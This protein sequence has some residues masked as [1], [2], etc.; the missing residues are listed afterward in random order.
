MKYLLALDQGTSSSRSI[1]F[2]QHG[3]L[4]AI[5]QQEL[6]Q[7]YPQNSWV[8][9][10]PMDIWQQQC[11]TAHSVLQQLALTPKDIAAIAITNQR[12]TTVVW[13][14]QSGLPIYPAIVWQD[15]RTFAYCEQLKHAGHAATILAK[16]G[17]VLDAYF[18][19]SKL[20][21]ILQHVPNARARAE[22]GQLAFGT[23]D[24]WL[25]WKLS[26]G[27]A[28][29]T[30]VSNASRTMLW[31]IHSQSW[32]ADL[33]KLFDIP[34][35]LLPEVFPSSH[36]FADC[37]LFGGSIP[38]AG[39][40]GDQQ[41]A[42]F[43]Q[44]CFNAGMA[45]NTYGTGCFALLHSGT[46]VPHS[47][48]GLISTHAAQIDQ[49]ANYALEGSV[50]IGG[51]LVQWLRDGLNAVQNAA[52]IE[53]LALSVPD[54]DGVFVVPAFTGLG[55]PYWDSQAKGAILGLSRGSTMAHIARASLEAIAYQTAEL[56]H[57]MSL[58]TQ[59]PIQELR[60]DGGAANNNL[61]LQ[62][63]ANLLG[64]EVIRPKITETTAL[65]AAF[66]AGLN[67]GIFENL[68]ACR[69]VWQEDTRFYPQIS[70]NKSQELMQAW[71]Q[72]VQRVR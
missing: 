53:A 18:S 3:Q 46:K 59:H 40:A 39:I 32:D 70:N 6:K 12:E 47:N 17:L 54:S 62:F 28:H 31:N 37:T 33:L 48:Y 44:C 7:S 65:G 41:A 42:L 58:D 38:I 30:D 35:A 15:R 11:Q 43:G 24:T 23:I 71:K 69:A 63:Q 67:Q 9:H 2:N 56:L 55:A 10:D 50:F 34:A 68:E 16:T 22:Q 25:T 21:W 57:S 72:A 1:L 20:A 13:D 64:I 5:A 26:E 60:V 29:V 49:Q 8:E 61:L 19:A 4:C 36:H 45:K 52:E 14:K 51:A 27:R 66:L